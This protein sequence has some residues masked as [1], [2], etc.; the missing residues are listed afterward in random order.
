VN[1]RNIL[2]LVII[3]L[4]SCATTG[5]NI[6]KANAHYKIGV[7]YFN[8]N[9]IQPAFVEFQKAIELNPD[10]KYALDALGLVY[11]KLEDFQKAQESFIKAVNIDPD[12]SEALNNLGVTYTKIGK[13]SEAVDSFKK[14]LKNPLYKT[15][16]NSYYNLGNAYYRLGLIDDAI[17][18]YNEVIKRMQDFHLPYYGLALCYNAKGQYGDASSAI[19]RAIELDPVYKGNKDKAMEDLKEKK[20]KA[21][22][23]EEQ[24]IVDYLEILKY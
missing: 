5:E 19:T 10:D 6:H 17:D 15:P 23:E 1:I 13:W 9:K 12:F 8:E 11:L 18:A 21:K 7:S 4:S 20:L 3:F 2:L 24:D 16:E 14:A 22:G